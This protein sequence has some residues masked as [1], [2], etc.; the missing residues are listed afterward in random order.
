[1]I[2]NKENN[3]NIR[4]AFIDEEY[5]KEFIDLFKIKSCLGFS[6][7]KI[8]NNEKVVDEIENNLSQYYIDIDKNK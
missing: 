2:K 6:I 3:K 4:I 5:N 7:I 1:M 8:Q